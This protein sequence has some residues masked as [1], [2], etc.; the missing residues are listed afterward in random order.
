MPGYAKTIVV[1]NLGGDPEMRYVGETGDIPV[2]NFSLAIN[3]GRSE[4]PTWVRV[5]AWRK[6]AETC[7]EYLSKGRQVLVEGDLPQARI[8]T[9]KDGEARANLEMTARRVVF[10]GS[11]PSDE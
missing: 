5:T 11:K 3:N 6:L 1:G 2:T 10:L 7:A 8:W 9:G 4:E